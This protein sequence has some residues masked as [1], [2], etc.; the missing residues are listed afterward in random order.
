[1]STM[2]V[3]C[4]MIVMG[5]SG[6]STSLVVLMIRLPPRSTRTDTLFPYTT[7]FRSNDPG[8]YNG[9]GRFGTIDLAIDLAIHFKLGQRLVPGLLWNH[10]DAYPP[11][12]HD[13][14]GLRRN[15]RGIRTGRA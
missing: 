4:G 5:V 9:L 12:R 7:L 10:Q 1:M 6:V 15:G 2:Y 13:A 11:P 8:S 3:Q 14:R